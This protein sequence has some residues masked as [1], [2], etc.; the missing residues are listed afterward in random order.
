MS[1]PYI[2]GIAVLH[3]LPSWIIFFNF[4]F[5]IC[6]WFGNI[7]FCFSCLLCLSVRDH[8]YF[9]FIMSRVI[10]KGK[11]K[12]VW[13]KAIEFG[14]GS[15][16][17]RKGIW[18]NAYKIMFSVLEGSCIDYWTKSLTSLAPRLQKLNIYMYEL[19]FAFRKGCSQW[20][21]NM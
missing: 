16:F 20:L 13:Q 11:F 5:R 1:F 15:S 2:P 8:I 9:Y 17:L 14:G 18:H 6:N 10:T 3:F 7:K 4:L 12:D 21:Y 19:T